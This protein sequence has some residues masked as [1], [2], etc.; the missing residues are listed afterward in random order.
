MANWQ[1]T[2]NSIARDVR[3]LADNPARSIEMSGRM[4]SVLVHYGPTLPVLDIVFP[5]YHTGREWGNVLKTS[6]KPH[7]RIQTA[8]GEDIDI[9]R[10]DRISFDG[11]LSM[12]FKGHLIF[13][14]AAKIFPS[15]TSAAVLC[16]YTLRNISNKPAR[17]WVSICREEDEAVETLEG[18]V[19]VSSRLIMRNS[20]SDRID[21]EIGAGSSIEFAYAVQLSKDPEPEWLDIKSELEHRRELVDL[22][23]SRAEF[24]SESIAID[25]MYRFAKLRAVESVFDTQI[26]PMHS[27]GGGG[28]FYGGI[29]CNDQAEYAFPLFP[30]LG[31]NNDVAIH[32]YELLADKMDES[33]RLPHSIEFAGLYLGP[34]ERGDAAMYAYGAS[35]FLLGLGEQSTAERLL[36]HIERAIDF[37]FAH[38]DERGIVH[39]ETD[40]LEG[41]Y[42]TGD[43]NLSTNSLFYAALVHAA[44]LEEVMGHEERAHAY[45]DA[46]IRL[47]SDIERFFGANIEGY[48]TYRYYDGNDKLRGW[49]CLPLAM[50][51]Y[52]RANATRDAI[53]S[54]KL[55]SEHGLKVVSDNENVWERETL[56]AIRGLFLAGFVEEAAIKLDE[57]SRRY[58]S[59]DSAPYVVEQSPS[60]TQLAAES[61]LFARIITEGLFGIEPHFDEITIRPKLP[62]TWQYA[63]I[64]HIKLQA[65]D[66]S[67][68]LRRESGAVFVKC[69][70]DDKTVFDGQLPDSG[71]ITLAS[72]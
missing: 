6:R 11:I 30:Y 51:I 46:A 17:G 31:I 67:I 37:E 36:P 3:N 61:A 69:D 34:F 23:A 60:F 38:M 21:F 5:Y 59:G 45:K 8:A 7:I 35:L 13:E 70:V 58:T 55:W 52:D 24:A 27:P 65:K 18:T 9:D 39:S 48:D 49:I 10:V 20:V 66:I 68:D 42:P 12:N 72:E 57:I 64:R 26:G 62:Q 14:T 22:A 54:D 28:G 53:L 71:D 50:G 29:W 47:H 33:G 4:A 32:D 43:A 41:R 44:E 56:Y 16:I 40:E 2:G 25:I 63:K 19:T 15:T 1:L